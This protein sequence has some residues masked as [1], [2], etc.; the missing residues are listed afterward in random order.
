MAISSAVP[1]RSWPDVCIDSF[2]VFTEHDEVDL[3]RAL[4]LEWNEDVGKR[5]NRSHIRIKIASKSNP[6]ENLARVLL[7]RYPR[8]AERP[9]KHT[10]GTTNLREH[11]FGQR[12]AVAKESIRPKVE[13]P[14]FERQPGGPPVELEQFAGFGD[15][16]FANAVPR[17]DGDLL[18]RGCDAHSLTR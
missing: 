12:R 9:E 7:A 18:G 5:A 13:I 6:E 16:F 14:Q 4:V 10:G 11:V 3:F 17:Q 1:R 2:G 15:D 8:I